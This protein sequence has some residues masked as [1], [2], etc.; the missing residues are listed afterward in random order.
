MYEYKPLVKTE[1]VLI[2][3]RLLKL[4]PAKSYSS[5]LVCSLE[6]TGFSMGGKQPSERVPAVTTQCETPVYTLAKTTQGES[7]DY[8]LTRPSCSVGSSDSVFDFEALS[9]AWGD[10]E[11]VSRI[12][13]PDNAFMPIASN[14]DAFLRHR[15]DTEKP[16]TL[17]I[18]ALCIDQNNDQEKSSQVG[19]MSLIYMGAPRL[20]IWLGPSRD[21]SDLAMDQINIMGHSTAFD[22]LPLYKREVIDAIG[23]LMNRDWWRRV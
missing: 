5:S 2:P 4:F 12:L 18:D 8:A 23:K 10:K 21:D 20:T 16:I 17:W 3:F 11:I 22:V 13:V 19:F 7:P 1:S 9:Y 15:R 6:T 14:L